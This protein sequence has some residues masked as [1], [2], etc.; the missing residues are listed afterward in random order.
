MLNSISSKDVLEETH[1]TL[2]HTNP[3]N[4]VEIGI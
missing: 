1:P 3:T 4:K 2:L